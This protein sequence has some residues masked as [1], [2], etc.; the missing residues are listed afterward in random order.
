MVKRD[1][2]F[3]YEI[4]PVDSL[5]LSSFDEMKKRLRK[6]S[7][8]GSGATGEGSAEEV[9]KK[10]EEMKLAEEGAPI[11]NT[12]DMMP[13]RIE[14]KEAALW[15]KKDLSG[16]KDFK[17]LE[18]ISDWTFSTPY[19]GTVQGLLDNI[20]RIKNELGL[21]LSKPTDEGLGKAKLSIEPTEEDIPVHRLGKDNPIL[22]Y[23]DVHLFEDELE[24]SGQA[25]SHVRFRVM[26]DCFYFLLR[27][28]L[29]VDH[30]VVRILD[31]RVFHD[32][33]TNTILREFQHKEATYKELEAA[34]FKLTSDWSLAPNASDLVFN[35]LQLKFKAKDKV[36]F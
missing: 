12:V 26:K 4:T 23:D 9:G 18:I 16:I 22:H 21:D 20:T 29:R 33:E 15:K 36:T 7:P 31:T 27:Y 13:E 3:L 6:G 30:V 32:F 25:M 35:N 10:L 2:N 17:Q 14:V 11:L 34:G 24:D 28:Y 5:N 8:E 19:K 1:R